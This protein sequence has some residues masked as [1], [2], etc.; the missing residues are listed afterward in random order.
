[1]TLAVALF[2]FGAFL[3]VVV[4]LLY[5]VLSDPRR[6]SRLERYADYMDRRTW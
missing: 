4:W 6:H 5:L 3:A 1:M 2:A